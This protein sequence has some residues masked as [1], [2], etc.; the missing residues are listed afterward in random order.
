MALCL[1]TPQKQHGEPAVALTPPKQ[2]MPLKTPDNVCT[3]CSTKTCDSC[4]FQ[5]WCAE[6]PDVVS[7]GGGGC[8]WLDL[9][10]ED[11]TIFCRVCNSFGSVQFTTRVAFRNLAHTAKRHAG[12]AVH[13]AAVQK[14]M[15]LVGGG[16]TPPTEHF[17][18]VWDAACKGDRAAAGLAHTGKRERTDKML[19]C[20]HEAIRLNDQDVLRRADVITLVR[21]ARKGRLLVRFIAVAGLDRHSGILGQAKMFGT[22]AAD[23]TR[24]TLDMI[25]KFCQLVGDLPRNR[26]DKAHGPAVDL[27]LEAH[28]L[29]HIEAHPL[30]VPS[31][32]HRD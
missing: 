1:A 32:H 23:V 11:C 28:I 26:L 10:P 31:N 22:T 14:C 20:I 7:I 5:A 3:C 18:D 27:Q 29:N 13:Q 16:M 25:H 2:L 8:R 21:D 6:H 9:D 30:H 15:G 19:W 12:C 17:V 4:R 24:A